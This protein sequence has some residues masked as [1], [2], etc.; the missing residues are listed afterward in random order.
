MLELKLNHVSK[1]GYRS[2]KHR[3]TSYDSYLTTA[4]S[5]AALLQ[6]LLCENLDENIQWKPKDDDGKWP[7]KLHLAAYQIVVENLLD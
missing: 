7:T 2:Q 1:R 4:V 3:R 6:W 5:Y